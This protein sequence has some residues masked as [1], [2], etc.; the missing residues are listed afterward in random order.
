MPYCNRYKNDNLNLSLAK[1]NKSFF[2]DF[3]L[4]QTKK[5]SINNFSL[6]YINSNL[7]KNKKIHN[8]FNNNSA[9]NVSQSANDNVLALANENNVVMENEN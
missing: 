9:N 6:F 3:I 1:K 4:Q 5:K 8:S 7:K 2:K